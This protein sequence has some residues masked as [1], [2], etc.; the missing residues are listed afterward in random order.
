MRALRSEN[1]PLDGTTPPQYAP[2]ACQQYTYCTPYCDR[3][4][5]MTDRKSSDSENHGRWLV[6]ESGCE[7][8]PLALTEMSRFVKS[9]DTLKKPSMLVRKGPEASDLNARTGHVWGPA[10]S[11]KN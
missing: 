11:T 4:L 1:S 5:S 8:F 2:N 9:P 6:S 10:G 7:N 3:M